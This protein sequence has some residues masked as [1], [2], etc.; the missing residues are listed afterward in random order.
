[1]SE[2][3]VSVDQTAEPT[4]FTG[5]QS[6]HDARSSDFSID[7]VCSEPSDVED[8]HKNMERPADVP[9]KFWDPAANT[10][11]TEAL[12]KSYRELER[13]LGKMVP[14]PSEEDPASRQR[15]HRA[16]GLPESPDDYEIR[17][18]H[19][20]ISSDP[21]I[22]AKLHEAGLT[23]DQAQLVYDLAAE[24]V[25][26][27]VEKVNDEAS[28]AQQLARLS[29]HFGGEESWQAIAP[30]IKSWAKANLDEHVYETLGSSFDGVVAIHHMMQSKEPNMISEAAVQ[31]S[32]AD[33]DTLTQMMRDPKYWR[34][35]DPA[36]VNKV[37]EGY[38][39]LYSQQRD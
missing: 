31:S 29:S 13:K 4:A 38:R 7:Q 1:M 27:I 35:H 23:A 33:R 16:L 36:F 22:N 17:A 28:N 9:D 6:E 8:G 34:D 19:E 2:Q 26:P 12:L 25:L 39:R 15:L 18:P 11:R 32:D 20:L 10:I 5:D 30:Q 21:E 37:T 24:H 14:L 3:E